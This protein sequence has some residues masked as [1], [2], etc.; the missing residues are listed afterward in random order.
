MVCFCF[1]EIHIFLLTYTEKIVN[2]D[3]LCWLNNL[4][5]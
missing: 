4:K 3:K 5:V 2:I 1:E